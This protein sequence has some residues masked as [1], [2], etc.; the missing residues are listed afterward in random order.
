MTT[1]ERREMIVRAALPLVCEFGAAVTTA[2]IARAAGIGE[3]TV[4][5]AF[6]DKDELLA[7]CVAEAVRADHVFAEVAAIPLDQPLA[8][9]LVQAV[10]AMR[11]HLTRVASVVGAL[12]TSGHRET[13]RGAPGGRQ[14]ML[15]RSRD[16]LADLM[17]PERDSLRLPVRQSAALFLSVVFAMARPADGFAPTTAETVDFFLY[18]ALARGEE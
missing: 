6:V 1:E 5:R 8:A 17:E 12:Q 18:G 16:L 15:S 4:F 14:E 7:A 10:D 3:A 13:R 2:K 11:A 9:R